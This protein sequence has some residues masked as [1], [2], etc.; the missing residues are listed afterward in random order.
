MSEIAKA[1]PTTLSRGDHLLAG[2]AGSGAV[3]CDE[4]GA[5]LVGLAHGKVRVDG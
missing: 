5:H 1:V 4:F 2:D 3:E